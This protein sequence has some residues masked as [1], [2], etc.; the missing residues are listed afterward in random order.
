MFGKKPP[1]DPPNVE[2]IDCSFCRKSQRDVRQIIAGPQVYICNECVDIC[3]EI[4]AETTERE[5]AAES[6]GSAWVGSSTHA[7]ALCRLTISVAEAIV[8][9]NRG[10]LCRGC[11]G[12]IQA[13]I[14]RE[15]MPG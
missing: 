5:S 12:E 14:A 8:V 3:L 2:L 6:E 9:D 15:K 11:V 1:I 10:L 13:A 4:M 7:C